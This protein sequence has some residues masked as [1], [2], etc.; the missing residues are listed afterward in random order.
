MAPKDWVLAR[1]TGAVLAD[2]LASVGLVGPDLAYA[3]GLIALVPGAAA[4]LAPLAD[5]LDIGGT[6]AADPFAGVPVVPGTMDAW[7]SLLGLGVAEPGQAMYL[8]GTS[9]VLGL[10]SP[11]R[12]GE[13]GV[14]TF[15]DWAGITLHAA[16]TQAG[17]ASLGWVSRLLGLPV[18][19]ALALAQPVTTDSPLF[20][21]HLQGERAP[22]WDATARGAFAG[23]TGAHGPGALVTAVLEGVAFSARLALEA[24]ERSGG[25]VPPEVRLGGGGAASDHWCQMRADVLGKPLLRMQ[26]RDPGAVGAAVMAGVGSGA[27]PGL[28]QAARALVQPDRRFLPDPARQALAD[29]RFTRWQQLYQQMRPVNAGFA[30]A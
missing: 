4:R 18:E 9:E 28:V 12:R 15:P 14:I 21:P 7:A 27:M 5:P 23:L 26:G 30:T 29:A 10:V 20:L 16:P 22:L 17:G 25:M 19:D 1:L 3:A 2:P 24:L 13:P 6:M 11:Q 8:S